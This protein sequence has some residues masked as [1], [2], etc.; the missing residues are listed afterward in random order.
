MTSLH[1][2]VQRVLPEAIA[3]RR[4]LHSHP[5]LSG[6]EHQTRDY[7][8]AMLEQWGIPYTLCTT[9]L[10]VVADIGRGEPCV[11]LR[12]DMDALPIAEQ[13]GL[14]YAS[15]V[16]GV[17]HAC[18]HDVHVAAL[19]AAGKV[20]KQMEPELNGTVRLLFQPAEE[21]TGGAADMIAEG[22]M[23]APAVTSVLGFH[24]DPNR[25]AGS[26]AFFPG[27][28][29]AAATDFTLTVHG[30]GCHGAHPDE[31]VDAIVAAA[32][33]ICAL[34]S[35][36]SRGIAP[37]SSGVVTIGTIHGGTKENIIADAVTMTGTIRA[38]SQD[39]QQL[40]KEK[41]AA[42]VTHT[43]AAF[44]ATAELQME[45]LCPALTND[46]PQ[47]HRMMELSRQLIGADKTLQMQEPSLGA[48]D[49]AFFS[50]AACGCY[51][52]VGARTEGL[53]GQSLHSPVFEPDERCLET[54]VLLSA[55]G[56]WMCLH[57]Q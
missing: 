36:I 11:A 20:L 28:M 10:G 8:C 54:A 21:T 42:I 3:M 43:A 27:T 30:K 7:I 48:D 13:T 35:A 34:Q 25:P 41:V 23:Q 26:A 45:D 56:A 39:I 52:N 50:N 44:G 24:V 40:L 46:L 31:G 15:E 5:E 14:P 49:F 16:P 22:C 1:E 2:A 33:V 37:T 6:Q 29:N 55:A 12:A 53:E 18:G 9:N 38:L 51:F 32:Q 47:T 17:M 4:H 19:L 57:G